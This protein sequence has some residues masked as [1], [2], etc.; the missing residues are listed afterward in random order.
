ML[1]IRLLSGEELPSIPVEEVRSVKEVKQRLHKQHGLPPRFRQRLVLEGADLEDEDILDC[2]LDL[3]LVLQS[4][5]SVSQTQV[6]E[7]VAAAEN[8]SVEEAGV[9]PCESLR[10]CPKGL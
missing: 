3:V 2:P 5:C 10:V 8:G 4:F 1:H 9:C 7:L 6:E